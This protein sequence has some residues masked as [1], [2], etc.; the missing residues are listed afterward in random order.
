MQKSG[1]WYSYGGDRIGQGKD[2]VRNFLKE[3]PDIAAEIDAKVR[4][5]VFGGAAPVVA[6]LA[7]KTDPVEEGF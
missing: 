1:S 4:E 5:K 2:N 7:G 3:H 6:K